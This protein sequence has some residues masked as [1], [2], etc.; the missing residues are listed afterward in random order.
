MEAE[1]D[2]DKDVEGSDDREDAMDDDGA[3]AATARDIG[4]DTGVIVDNFDNDDFDNNNDDE[5]VN[6]C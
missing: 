3:L 1:D 6:D 2:E 4:S 5:D